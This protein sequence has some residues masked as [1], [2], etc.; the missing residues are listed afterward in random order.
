MR[1]QGGSVAYVLDAETRG[2]E[3]ESSEL[4]S[5]AGHVVLERQ[6]QGDPKTHWPASLPKLMTSMLSERLCL[7]N[8]G[9]EEI[10]DVDL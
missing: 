6:R 5:N 4:K 8:E 9:G 1:W 2:T 7:K 3:V 10:E